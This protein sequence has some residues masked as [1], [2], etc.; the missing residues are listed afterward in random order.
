MFKNSLFKVKKLVLATTLLAVTGAANAGYTIKLD[1]GD[2]LTFGGYVKVDA[3]YISGDIGA[4][5]Y[6]YGGGTVLA[7][8]QSNFGI[9]ANETRFNTKYIHGDVTGFIEIDFYGDAVK[10]GGNELISNSS[11]V[12]LRHAFVK[13]KNIL[14]GQTW[15]TFQN[16]SS[17]AEAAD[18]GGPLVASAFIRQGQIRYTMGAL[19]LSIE[20]PASYGGNNIAQ[21]GTANDSIPDF[22]GKYTFKGDWGNVSLSGLARQLES[23]SGNTEAAVGVGVAGRINTFGKD[24]FR[25]QL[26]AGNTGRYVGVTAATDMVGEEIEES[27]AVMAAYRHF[28][29]ETLRS[30]VFFGYQETEESDRER[31]H[32]GVNLFTNVTKQL[33][34]G[35]EV[36]SFAIDDNA[37]GA[38]TGDSAYLQFSTKFVL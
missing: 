25:F 37:P 7:E 6:W 30:S 21:G 27:I 34:F 38:K 13:Y 1:D 17:L 19:Q 31:Y 3:R 9:S 28:W 24:D 4:T 18:F 5:D 12:R 15:T 22:I 32:V 20:N 35:I 11:N 33:S 29:T 26:H 23:K 14:V 36:G 8:S 16:T 10:G 2:S